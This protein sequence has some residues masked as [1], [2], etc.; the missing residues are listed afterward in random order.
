MKTSPE[1]LTDI[2][3]VL[4]QINSKIS[5]TQSRTTG[6]AAPV[7][8]A[9]TRTAAGGINLQDFSSSKKEIGGVKDTAEAMK[10]LSSAL[11]PLSMCKKLQK[12]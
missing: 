9:S 5:G 2:L 6:A 12:Y 7:A 3:G 10:I 1:L 11:G 4:G 8:S